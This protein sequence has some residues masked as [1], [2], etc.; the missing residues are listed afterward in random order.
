MRSSILKPRGPPHASHSLLHLSIRL[1]LGDS[2]RRKRNTTHTTR[3]S[4]GGIHRTPDA[5]HR[6]YTPRRQSHHHSRLHQTNLP[7]HH[8]ALRTTA[9]STRNSIITLHPITNRPVEVFFSEPQTNDRPLHRINAPSLKRTARYS[10]NYQNSTFKKNLIYKFHYHH[11]LSSP[12]D[13][14]LS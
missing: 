3:K 4:S 13:P 7:H 5:D 6:D 2:G 14:F 1:S 12:W 9:P 10:R 11:R 8:C